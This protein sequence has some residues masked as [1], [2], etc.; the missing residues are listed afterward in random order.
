MP[1]GEHS[2]DGGPPCGFAAAKDALPPPP[3]CCRSADPS[4]SRPGPGE[5]GYGEG[6]RGRGRGRGAASL[7]PH[8]SQTRHGPPPPSPHTS[9]PAPPTL[10]ARIQCAKAYDDRFGVTNP[11][12]VSL[13]AVPRSVSPGRPPWLLHTAPST[14][15]SL[16]DASSTGGPVFDDGGW[17]DAPPD[18]LRLVV[19]RLAPHDVQTALLVCRDWRAGFA[20]GLLSLRPRLLRVDRLVDG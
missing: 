20:A 15:S 19:S 2:G 6:E 1:F 3:R 14:S 8:A 18:V 10:R 4:P 16:D 9:T 11:P 5:R 12:F 17:A 7:S 13:F